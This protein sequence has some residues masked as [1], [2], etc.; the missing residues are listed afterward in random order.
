MWYAFLHPAILDIVA[1]SH[2]A[3]KTQGACAED[4]D[5]ALH[6]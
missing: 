1:A 2:G 5:G 4:R 3:G 6:W